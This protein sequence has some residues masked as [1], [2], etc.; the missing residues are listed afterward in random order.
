MLRKLLMSCKKWLLHISFGFADQAL[1]SGANFFFN[2]L[3]VRWLMPD[4]Y[5][6]FAIAFSI[7]LFLSGF[8]NALI[9]QPASVIG[10]AYYQGN[11]SKYFG[12]TTLINGVL[13]CGFTVFLLL[14]ALIMAFFHYYLALSFLGLAIATPFILLFW[15]FRQI[16]YIKTRPDLAWR[17][18]FLYAFFLMA[19]V[20]VL[21]NCGSMS[22]FSAFMVMAIS[23][24]LSALFFWRYLD[25]DKIFHVSKVPSFIKGVLAEHWCYGRWVVGSAFVNWLSTLSYLPL[26]GLWAGVQQAGAF[27]AMQ[28][29]M[30]PLERSLSIFALLLIPWISKNRLLRGKK[31]VKKRLFALAVI[32]FSL[33]SVYGLFLILYGDQLVRMLYGPGYAASFV[34][35]IP[36][37]AIIAIMSALVQVLGIG[38]KSLERP[39]AIFW[40]ETMST[41]FT[42]TVGLYFVVTF[43]IRGAALGLLVSTVVTFLFLLYFLFKHFRQKDNTSMPKNKI[44]VNEGP[45][46][47]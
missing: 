13:T 23:S 43:K 40:A 42:L 11:L 15:L 37:F 2:V 28:N 19:G 1:L 26:V 25:I 44:I 17:A 5:G 21:K 47:E 7:F 32:N 8:Q 22:A 10:A 16:C 12:V 35:M 27:R 31:Y 33:A 34:W 9:L 30:L 45:H 4:E 36:Y 29:L 24:L 3:L 18:S 41:V 38:L 14:V 39:D 6:V 46:Y 20:V